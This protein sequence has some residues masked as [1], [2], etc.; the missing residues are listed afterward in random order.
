MKYKYIE[1]AMTHGKGCAAH[2]MQDDEDI[3]RGRVEKTTGY[4]FCAPRR[5]AV[6]EL[7]QHVLKVEDI[8]ARHLLPAAIRSLLYQRIRD[9][10]QTAPA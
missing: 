8:Y 6:Q 2:K 7:Q 5:Q 3:H 1:Q 4:L 10:L 9:T